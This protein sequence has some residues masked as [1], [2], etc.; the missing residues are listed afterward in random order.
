MY[1]R[2]GVIYI[3][4]GGLFPPKWIII[5]SLIVAALMVYHYR[6]SL[7]TVLYLIGA[8]TVVLTIA[9]LFVSIWSLMVNK[10]MR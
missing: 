9:A 8:I 5:L 4:V 2:I 1:I 10:M 3:E 6:E 7:D